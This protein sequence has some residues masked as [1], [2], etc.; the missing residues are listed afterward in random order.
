[1]AVFGICGGILAFVVYLLL[2]TYGF[3][4]RYIVKLLGAAGVAVGAFIVLEA[5]YL[6]G[7]AARALVK[8]R[9]LL[10]RTLVGRIV[11]V[12]WAALLVWVLDW[13]LLTQNPMSVRVVPAPTAEQRESLLATAAAQ[14]PADA[15]PDSL[16]GDA[17]RRAQFAVMLERV[18]VNRPG[19]YSAKAFMEAA[20]KY[21]AKYGVD[22]ILQYY[23]AY[24]CSFYGEAPAGRVP[25]LRAMTSETIRD[26]VQV[27]L[28]TFLVEARWRRKLIE[29]PSLDGA[30]FLGHGGHDWKYAIQK[31]TYDVSVEPFDTNVY[32]D[33][34]LVLREFPSEF[35]EIFGNA[36][37]E[38][39]IDRQLAQSFEALKPK[40]MTKPYDGYYNEPAWTSDDYDT[41]RAPLKTFARATFYKLALDIDFATR[42]QTL[43]AKYYM[44]QYRAVLGEEAWKSLGNA[45]QVAMVAMLRD[46]YTPN[47]GHV[48]ANVYNLPEFNLA[49]FY[50]VADAAKQDQAALLA[51]AGIWKPKDE[52]KLWA[53]AN[54]KLRALSEV[55]RTYYGEPL[56]G[57]VP[58]ETLQDAENVV[59]R[60]L[61]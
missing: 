10:P 32:T 3:E 37:G 54:T 53:A 51:S 45:K 22:P 19:D 26:F 25:F 21:G 44:D 58:T 11:M 17:K 14:L 6:F 1:L 13:M 15:L 61:R 18:A 31:A 35:P 39:A 29:G 23:W 41:L 36:A 5:G 8:S 42:V 49:P 48:S 38:Q 60:S 46:V 30:S 28:P 2:N 50:F 57:V 33:V 9:Y 7:R 59:V 16:R 43:I 27:H 52:E 55:W 12:L 56:P 4:Y 20:Q 40:F 47:I 34:F 24:L